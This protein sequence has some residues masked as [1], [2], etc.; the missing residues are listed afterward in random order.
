MTLTGFAMDQGFA[1]KYVAV[2]QQYS[3]GPRLAVEFR[4]NLAIAKESTA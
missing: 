2:L 4:A 1:Q 3:D